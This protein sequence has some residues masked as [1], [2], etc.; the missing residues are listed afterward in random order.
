MQTWTSKDFAEIQGITMLEAAQGN[1]DMT[2]LRTNTR[3]FLAAMPS[4]TYLLCLAK[5]RLK[6]HYHQ[7]ANVVKPKT[8]LQRFGLSGSS[9]AVVDATVDDTIEH[10]VKKLATML[11]SIGVLEDQEVGGKLLIDDFKVVH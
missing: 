4:S 2:V 5:N 9:Q 11:K 7:S 6:L 3:Y 1:L 10:I 8:W